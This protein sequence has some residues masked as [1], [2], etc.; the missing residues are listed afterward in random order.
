MGGQITEYAIPN[1]QTILNPIEKFPTSVHLFQRY[2]LPRFMKS[3]NSAFPSSR[4]NKTFSYHPSLG[5]LS[6]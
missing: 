3:R 5:K 6:P 1:R 2:R 4:L